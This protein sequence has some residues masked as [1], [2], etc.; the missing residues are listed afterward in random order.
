MNRRHHNDRHIL[1]LA[2]LKFLRCWRFISAT[3]WHWRFTTDGRTCFIFTFTRCFYSAIYTAFIHAFPENQSMTSAL[4]L[5]TK[6][7][8]V[9]INNRSFLRFN[10]KISSLSITHTSQV[11]CPRIGPRPERPPYLLNCWAPS[12][13]HREQKKKSLTSARLWRSENQSYH[14]NREKHK[15]LMKVLSGMTW[16]QCCVYN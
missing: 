11:D 6:D 15:R 16:R 3:H 7:T 14:L 13:A 2:P 12:P 4:L 8:F 5:R 10:V 1:Y 9:P